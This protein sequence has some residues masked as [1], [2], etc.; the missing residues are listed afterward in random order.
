MNRDEQIQEAAE[1]AA[2]KFWEGVEE[3]PTNPNSIF[4]LCELWFRIGAQWADEHSLE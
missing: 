4:S 2:L 1:K 3:Y